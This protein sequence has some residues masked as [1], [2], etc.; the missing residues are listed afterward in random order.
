MAEAK[1]WFTNGPVLSEKKMFQLPFSVLPEES[2]LRILARMKEL[3][4]RLKW[5]DAILYNNAG[6]KYIIVPLKFELKPFGNNY[7]LSR[8][9]VFY[10][11]NT[12]VINI[13][14]VEVLSKKGESLQGKEAEITATVVYNNLAQKNETIAGINADVFFY[15]DQ[16]KREAG[17]EIKSG[18]WKK[19]N[20]RLQIK[21][22]V[23]NSQTFYTTTNSST[24]CQLWY[25]V[26]DWYNSNGDFVYREILY[27]YY[28]GECNG[29][30]GTLLTQAPGEGGGGGGGEVVLSPNENIDAVDDI[31]KS[32]FKFHQVIAPTNGVGGWRAAGTTDIHM[33]IVDLTTGQFVPIY[34]PTIYF[35]LPVIRANGEYYSEN[36]AKEIAAEA[37][38]YAE[39]KVM[40][41]YH[42]LGGSLDI[43]GMTLYYRQKINEKMQQYAGTAT[44][45]PGSNITIVELGTAS[46]GWPI[47]GC[48]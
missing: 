45:S 37:V 4:K 48:L 7:E 15:N 6:G 41:Y 24:N 36:R 47:I 40:E 32:S 29:S 23:E 18:A 16:Y 5:E 8:S 1:V 43:V 28:I 31:C 42:S 9:V 21:D 13:K 39:T 26:I 33:K 30:N 17:F 14:I 34:L 38:E 10:K 25:L 2:P 27:S 46:Y 3:E 20:N 19:T 11:T 44:L 35:G 12:N 22:K